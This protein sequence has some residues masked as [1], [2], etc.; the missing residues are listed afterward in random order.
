M[1]K[2]RIMIVDDDTMV[3]IGLKTVI[4]W[5]EN[6]FLLVGEAQDG[7][8]A[9][10][11]AE[12]QRPDIIITDIKM[13]G[14]DGIEL[15][16]QLRARGNPA[17]ILV[18]SSYDEFDLVKKALKLG[19]RD[20]LLKLNLE[21]EEL[22]RGLRQIVEEDGK[23]ADVPRFSMEDERSRALLRQNFLWDV[24]SNF[25]L[26]EKQLER[27][28]RELDIRLDTRLVCCM[29]LKTGELYRF[30]D[31]PAEELQTLRF[32]VVNIAEEIVG[33][34]FCGYCFS[35]KTGEFYVLMAGRDAG[36]EAVVLKM[37]HR[38]RRML[39]EYL[40]LSCMVLIG[41]SS[42]PGSRGIKEAFWKANA[43]LAH[44]FYL[45][46]DGVLLWNG[47]MQKIRQDS[48]SLS[49]VR[50]ELNDILLTGGP[51]EL[52]RVL[53]RL[54]EDMRRLE[55]SRSAVCGVALE[56]FYI[57]QEYFDKNDLSVRQLLP[58]SFRT[59]EQ[60][61]HMETMRE[62]T[63][64]MQ[65]LQSDLTAFMKR[66]GEKG[67]SRIA[68]RVMDWIAAHY[69]ENAT[70][71]EAARVVSLNPSYLSTLLKKY[72]GH[73]YTE[74][75]TEYRIERAKE[76]LLHTNE[77]VYRVGQL[78]GYEDK[79]YFNR[80]FKRVT[81]MSPGEFKSLSRKEPRTDFPTE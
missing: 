73:S 46:H 11:L 50:A 16:R 49:G 53:G 21:P 1:R 25:Y 80:I 8:R 54:A 62:V 29:I 6:G 18:L 26:D 32:S 4:N 61:L 39:M 67:Y 65:S 69:Q 31:T 64:W 48:Y 19:A 40:N 70:L 51:E 3:R 60:L 68:G 24:V 56:L 47:E 79:Y 59:Y 12:T 44:R 36:E 5:E 2:P 57:V 81:G 17:A 75:L 71:Q 52:G 9:L 55:L 63:D 13:P 72:T 42:E 78:V 33:D 35:G 43:V 58:R 10:A 37:A 20:Y 41:S 74:L 45:D 23:A 14:M 38:L 66:E 30:E 7:Q 77:K 27:T 34:V 76:L 22:L 15:I 28:M